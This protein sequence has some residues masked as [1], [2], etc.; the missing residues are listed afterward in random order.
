MSMEA[1]RVV[2]DCPVV[3]IE[4][5]GA[6]VVIVVFCLVRLS[7]CTVRR[8]WMSRDLMFEQLRNFAR[9]DAWRLLRL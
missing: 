1:R 5:V 7:S 6:A 3:L 8:R 2:V 4:G 9:S